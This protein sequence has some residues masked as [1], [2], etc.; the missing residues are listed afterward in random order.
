MSYD[1]QVVEFRKDLEE[2][3]D[4]MAKMRMGSAYR[5]DDIRSA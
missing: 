4:L 1:A 3:E 5:I 2:F